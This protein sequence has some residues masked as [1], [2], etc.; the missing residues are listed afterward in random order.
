MALTTNKYNSNNRNKKQHTTTVAPQPND[1]R[2]DK[3]EEQWKY[4]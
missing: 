1:E 4:Y 3:E 2:C